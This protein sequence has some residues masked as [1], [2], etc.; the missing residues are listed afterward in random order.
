VRTAIFLTLGTV[1][2]AQEGCMT[3]FSAVVALRHS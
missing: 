2:F 3:P 1:S